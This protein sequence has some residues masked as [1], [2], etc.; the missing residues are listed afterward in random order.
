M[1]WLSK[2]RVNHLRSYGPRF[3]SKIPLGSIIVVAVRPEIPPLLR[4]NLTLSLALLLVLFNLLILINL[5]YE[6]AYTGNKFPNQRP[7]QAML[8]K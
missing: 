2:Y 1:C 3:P 7:S 6:L 5:I 8:G 4:D